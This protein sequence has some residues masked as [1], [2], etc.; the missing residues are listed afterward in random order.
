MKKE[1]KKNFSTAAQTA[2]R[3]VEMGPRMKLQLVKITEGLLDGKV[4][5]HRFSKQYLR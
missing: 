3:L 2:V 5:Y 1:L 4:I